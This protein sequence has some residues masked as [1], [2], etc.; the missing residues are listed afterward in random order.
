MRNG[1]GLRFAS[2]TP[3]STSLA[4]ST[5]SDTLSSSTAPPPEVST[6]SLDDATDFSSGFLQDIP[7]HI[8]YLKSLG[9]DYGRGPTACMEWLL[10]HV[11]VYAGTPWWVS[12]ALSAVVV[13][14]VLFKPYIDAA[15]NASRLQVV[16]PL[17][18]PL[19]RKMRDA[20][21]DTAKVLEIRRE[22]QI[23]NRRAG[24]K[25][26]KTF[27]PMSQAFAGYGM[28]VLLRAMA[29]V[30]VPGLES[31]GILWFYNL[32]VPDPYFIIPVATAFL[33]HRLIKVSYITSKMV[34]L[35]SSDS[36]T[37][38]SIERWRNRGTD[39]VA[40][41]SENALRRLSSNVTRLHRIHACRS[42]IILL[43]VQYVVRRSS[44]IV[45]MARLP[46][47]LEHVPL[48]CKPA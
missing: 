36:K 15:D 21:G 28:F 39:F 42:S 30:P 40:S 35:A 26:W 17:T 43:R 19:T 22:I 34:P 7:E 38:Y 3:I 32:T 12:I 45:Q 33:L 37:Y 31:G 1:A 16:K 9:L 44:F 14:A 23:I 10:E 6:S 11:H 2:T 13:R 48:A 20:K 8:G 25:I 24:I 27:V 5:P 47:I 46:D 41:S 29:K 4:A 18:D